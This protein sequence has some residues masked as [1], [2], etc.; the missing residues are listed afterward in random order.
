M[1]EDTLGFSS[2]ARTWLAALRVK[3]KRVGIWL[4]DLHAL[5]FNV[6]AFL[7]D[8]LDLV[9]MDLTFELIPELTENS[10][11]PLGVFSSD[12]LVNWLRNKAY[13]GAPPMIVEGLEPLLATFTK[14]RVQAFFRLASDL[15]VHSPL[16]LVTYLGPLVQASGFP[17]DRVLR[18]LTE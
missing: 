16:I 12:D 3:R 17:S 7:A 18:L 9:R 1:N 2:L 14:P 15:D 10:P 11:K 6:A 5:Q 13:R 8:D 4:L